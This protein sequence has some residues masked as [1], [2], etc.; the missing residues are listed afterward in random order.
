MTIVGTDDQGL[1]PGGDVLVTVPAG[2]TRTHTA[3]ELEEGAE[4]LE[5]S[6]GDGA[7]KWRL[8]GDVRRQPIRV[9]SLLSSPTGHLTNLSTA[10]ARGSGMETAAEV[11]R[12][13]DLG[14]D[15]AIEVR[16]L[17]C[18]GEASRGTRV[19]CS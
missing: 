4:G 7:G 13:A 5:G 6:L 15:R 19:W 12:H 3:Q 14:T 9:L 16:E 1:S 17:S 18:R 8:E 10:T 2:G 11:F